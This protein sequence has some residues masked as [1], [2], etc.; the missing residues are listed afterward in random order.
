MLVL[1]NCLKITQLLSTSF[2]ILSSRS[3]RIS[4]NDKHLGTRPSNC[5]L[6]PLAQQQQDERGWQRL[7]T[8]VAGLGPES[9]NYIHD[10]QEFSMDTDSPLDNV[11]PQ[12]P[13]EP[14]DDPEWET[15]PNELADNE[16]FTQAARDLFDHQYVSIFFSPVALLIL[17]RYGHLYKDSRTWRQRIRRLHENWEPH[18]A[19]MVDAYLV[20]RY[21]PQSSTSSSPDVDMDFSFTI[22]TLDIYNLTY[23]THIP[24]QSD[25]KSVAQA[26]MSQGYIG[27]TPESP[28]F[29]LSIR[30]LELFRRIHLR[31]ASFSVEAFSK[32]I[33][34]L[35]NAS[36]QPFS[37]NSST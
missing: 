13:T 22:R 9:M 19:E 5:L 18:L 35:Y 2:S 23:D 24:R 33:C 21:S 17:H 16:V 4:T 3:V 8:E 7:Q 14:Q 28:S 31:K 6:G 20:W 37:S 36:I 29:A 34:D 11:A 1:E 26:L 12:L 10:M 25:S 15:V 27:N 32:V 30:T